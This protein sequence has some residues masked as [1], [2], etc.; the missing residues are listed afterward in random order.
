MRP[1]GASFAHADSVSGSA[2]KSDVD[3]F[4]VRIYRR[5][6]DPAQGPVGTVECVACGER[7]GFIGRDELF[8]RLFVGDHHA[9]ERDRPD[10][11]NP[12][13]ES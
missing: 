10:R 9:H 4:I 11:G 12:T 3:T 6:S 2:S 13:A 8:D 5:A 1:G 7:I